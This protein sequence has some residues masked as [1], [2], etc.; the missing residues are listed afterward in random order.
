MNPAYWQRQTDGPLFPQLEWSRPQNRTHAGKLLIVGGHAQGFA[1][2]AE[3][4]AA[5]QNAG[6]GSSRVLLPD[7]LHKTIGK[8]FPEAEFAPSNPSGGFAAT[9]LGELL[10]AASWADGVI[11]P[12][13]A[14]HNS[15]TL[16]L[17]ENFAGKYN[18]QLTI[19]ADAADHFCS[20][21]LELLQRPD[22]LLVLAMGQLQHLG[23]EAHFPQAFTSDMGL[24]QLVEQLHEFTR[25]FT[26]CLL[27]R[28]QNTF[29][30]AVNGRV[31]TT[32]AGAGLPTWRAK[33]AARAAVWWLQNPAKTFEALTTALWESK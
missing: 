11:V 20:Q 13:S 8:L 29:V 30:L 19:T 16:V 28:H 2:P 27:T 22:T 9:A 21:P 3:A 33:T 23:S 6:I 7:A 4:Y 17:L 12:G 24:V 5:A 14:G 10:D 31:S 25:R 26:P 15:E 32:A 1:G 18:G